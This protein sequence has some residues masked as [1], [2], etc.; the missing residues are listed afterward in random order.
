MRPVIAVL[1]SSTSVLIM[2]AKNSM[3]AMTTVTGYPQALY[4]RFRSGEF[5][6]VYYYCR[7]Y[8]HIIKHTGEYYKRSKL[9][10]TSKHD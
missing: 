1:G 10:K 7:N 9:V 8:K 6:S 2:R 3:I 4:G 5:L